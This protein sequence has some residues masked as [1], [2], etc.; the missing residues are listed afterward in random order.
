MQVEVTLWANGGGTVVEHSTA[1]PEID[2]S[3]PADTR[4]LEMRKL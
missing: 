2:G 4:H 1:D 3:N